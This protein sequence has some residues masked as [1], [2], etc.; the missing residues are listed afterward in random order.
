[1]ALSQKHRSVLFDHFAPQVGDGH[2]EALMAE[3]RGRDGDELV[4][5]DFLRAELNEMQLRLLAV[6]LAAMSVAT[7]VI[8]ATVG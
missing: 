2:A 8:I 4:T 1:M 6:L 7:G 5:K 3:L